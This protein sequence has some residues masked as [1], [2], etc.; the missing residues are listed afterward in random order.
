MT[1][2][3]E[4]PSEPEAEA[5]DLRRPPDGPEVKL[6]GSEPFVLIRETET[7]ISVIA[8]GDPMHSIGLAAQGLAYLQAQV[9]IN[10]LQAKQRELARKRAGLHPS[11]LSL[12]TSDFLKP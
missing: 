3:P 10:V 2:A 7:G 8:P 9:T 4:T 1:D 11:G 6:D 5:P 12:P